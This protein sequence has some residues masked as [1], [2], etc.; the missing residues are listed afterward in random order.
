MDIVH[1]SMVIAIRISSVARECIV[2]RVGPT[3]TENVT[4]QRTREENVG[5]MRC[6][7]INARRTGIPSGSKD[8]VLNNVLTMFP[9]I[10]SE[11]TGKCV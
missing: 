7:R 8:N 4:Q 1:L 10:Q 6:A 3:S 9:D 2:E 11:Y 5:R